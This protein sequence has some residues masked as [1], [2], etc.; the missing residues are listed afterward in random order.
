MAS[1]EPSLTLL[2]EDDEFEEF[3]EAWAPLPSEVMQNEEWEA[4]WDEEALEDDQFLRS[5][6]AKLEQS[7]PKTQ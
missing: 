5:L 6:R 1:S 4:D 3:E 7:A 2:E